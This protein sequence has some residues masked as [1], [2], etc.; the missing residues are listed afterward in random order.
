MGVSVPSAGDWGGGGLDKIDCTFEENST[1]L[2]VIQVFRWA[3]PLGG[4]EGSRGWP[5]GSLQGWVS[6]NLAP[7]IFIAPYFCRCQAP[8]GASWTKQR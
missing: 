3:R 2:F 1:L 6:G 5:E 7:V 8:R 4:L